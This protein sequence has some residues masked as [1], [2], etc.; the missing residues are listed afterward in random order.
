[1][2]IYKSVLVC[3]LHS[4]DTTDPQ[5]DC[6]VLGPVVVEI[7]S[8]GTT[9]TWLPVTA[10]DLS[11]TTVSCT[12]NPGGFFSTGVTSVTCTAIDDFG[13][14]NQCTF[15]VEVREGKLNDNSI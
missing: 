4:V 6:P 15:D 1:M 2:L 7:L 3:F 12:H 14:L 8:G 9:V 10:M 11:P 13:N 5:I